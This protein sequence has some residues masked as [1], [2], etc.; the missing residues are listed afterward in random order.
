VTPPFSETDVREF[1]SHP[2]WVEVSKRISSMNV[3]ADRAIEQS[4]PFLHGKA[5]GERQITRT[6]LGLPERF[7]AEIKSGG[8]P[9]S[10]KPDTR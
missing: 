1:Q 2:V 6:I 8:R 4:D 3:E 7:L 5:V 10:I 9:V